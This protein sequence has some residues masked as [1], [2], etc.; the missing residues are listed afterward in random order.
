[1]S[2]DKKRTLNSQ[3]RIN[4]RV[5]NWPKLSFPLSTRWHHTRRQQGTLNTGMS[6]SPSHPHFL[7]V[8]TKTNFLDAKKL[9][10]GAILEKSLLK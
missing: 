3:K 10:V 4:L 8:G 6:L 7:Q 1:M 2:Q 5:E 9:E